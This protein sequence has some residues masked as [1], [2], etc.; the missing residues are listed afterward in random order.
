MFVG[1]GLSHLLPAPAEPNVCRTQVLLIS[2]RLQRS[3]MF[4]VPGLLISSRLHRSRMFV[5]PVLST[6]PGYATEDFERGD[7][8]VFFLGFVSMTDPCFA[9]TGALRIPT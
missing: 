3:R 4:V 5:G 1:P 8:R 7:L 2:S 9:G 6:P